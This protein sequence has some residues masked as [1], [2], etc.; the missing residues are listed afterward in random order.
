MRP[1]PTPCLVIDADA[2]DA[3]LREAARH[4]LR[5]RPHFKAH[6]CVPLLRRQL[7]AAG[8][9]G[10]TCATAAEAL[11]LARAGIGDLL[12]IADPGAAIALFDRMS[13]EQVQAARAW[14][15]TAPAYRYALDRLGQARG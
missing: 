1:L 11:V 10:V 13:D 2:V 5:I 3:N 12:G 6:K 9:A 7:A 15:T 14:L 4:C 8:H